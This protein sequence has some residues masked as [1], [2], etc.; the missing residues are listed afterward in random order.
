MA[1]VVCGSLVS[2]APVVSICM[3]GVRPVQCPELV[4]ASEVLVIAPL[5]AGS[6]NQV[7]EGSPI[8]K[9]SSRAWQSSH[10]SLRV[11][12]RWTWASAERA[13]GGA[14]RHLVRHHQIA[15]RERM[16]KNAGRL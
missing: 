13:R 8:N 11:F 12:E 15:S 3:A 1:T 9:D 2:I 7:H 14:R 16:Q 6:A 5:D 10:L 4:G